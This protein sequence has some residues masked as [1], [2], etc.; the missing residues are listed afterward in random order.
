MKN[1]QLLAVLLK[2]CSEDD[3]RGILR[4]TI[5]RIQKEGTDDHETDF[6]DLENALLEVSRSPDAWRTAR[7]LAAEQLVGDVFRGI[8]RRPPTEEETSLCSA[9]LIE[10]AGLDRL[11]AA[12]T[13]SDEALSSVIRHNGAR[14]AID[15]VEGLLGRPPTDDELAHYADMLRHY[16]NVTAMLRVITKSSDFRRSQLAPTKREVMD[17]L[18]DSAAIDPAMV[19]DSRLLEDLAAADSPRQVLESVASRLGPDTLDRRDYRKAHPALSYVVSPRP[20]LESPRPL[21]LIFLP[22]EAWLPFGLAVA[23]RIKEESGCESVFVWERWSPAIAQATGMSRNAFD[24]ISLPDL[25]RLPDSCRFSPR[26]IVSHSYGWVDQTASLIR[27]FPQAALMVYGDAFNNEVR[28]EALAPH[29]TIAAGYFFGFVPDTKG[30]CARTPIGSATVNAYIEKVAAVYAIPA[31]TASP[32]EGERFAV[33]YLRYWGLGPYSL[34][35]GEAIKAM[36]DTIVRS[37]PRSV[38]LVIKNDTRA[39]EQLMPALAAALRELDFKVRTLEDY[40][41][42]LGIDP[43]YQELPA[44]YLFTQGLLAGASWHIVFDSSLSYLIS[45]SR[46][47]VRPTEVIIGGDLHSLTHGMGC[48]EPASRATDATPA[49]LSADLAR[50]SP[51]ASAVDWI[52][53]YA[54]HYRQAILVNIPDARLLESDDRAFFRIR[55]GEPARVDPAKASFGRGYTVGEANKA[56]A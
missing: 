37:L 11:A 45:T 15:T 41:S 20:R 14:L 7:T 31:L 56:D 29:G 39:S 55:L 35:P 13:E 54:N 16:G 32:D 22:T 12:I 42:A 1:L 49:G 46:H 4:K 26:F 25:L 52:S 8:L 21:A 40:L 18:Q 30:I 27:R 47:I 24:A 9:I 3:A 33:V 6:Q 17:L 34:S 51:R 2:V 28:P 50:S 38:P 48:E 36:T 5:E 10:G 19:T 43:A 23:D 44:E 53:R